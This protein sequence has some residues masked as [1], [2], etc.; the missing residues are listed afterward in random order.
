[1]KNYISDKHCGSSH[2]LMSPAVT[3]R[4]T[5][6]ASFSSI[7]MLADDMLHYLAKTIIKW[8]LRTRSLLAYPKSSAVKSSGTSS[9]RRPSFQGSFHDARLYEYSAICKSIIHECLVN[10]FICCSFRNK[11]QFTLNLKRKPRRHPLLGI[12]LETFN[13][14]GISVWKR[15]LRKLSGLRNSNLVFHEREVQWDDQTDH[16]DDASDKNSII[17]LYTQHYYNTPSFIV[18]IYLCVLVP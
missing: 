9:C 18:P 17:S 13:N 14:N 4:S 10:A 12:K 5:K 11:C 7:V 16:T 15:I 6:W 3:S 1:M 8:Y 2:M